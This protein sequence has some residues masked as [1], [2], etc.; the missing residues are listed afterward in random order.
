[1][2]PVVQAKVEAVLEDPVK[3]TR[4]PDRPRWTRAPCG[5]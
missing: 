5:T 3:V 2:S 1:M 4:L